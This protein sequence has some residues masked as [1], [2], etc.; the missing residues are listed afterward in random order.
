VK[1]TSN[2]VKSQP[3]NKNP[4]KIYLLLPAKL[5]AATLIQP[6][7]FTPGLVFFTNRAAVNMHLQ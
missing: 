7:E 2:G 1:N 3:V 6:V 5:F 4:R